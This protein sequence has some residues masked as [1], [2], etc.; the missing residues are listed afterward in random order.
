M[1]TSKPTRRILPTTDKPLT[2]MDDPLIKAA[3]NRLDSVHHEYEVGR[4]VVA[5]LRKYFPQDKGWTIVPEFLVP[6]RKKP[7]YCVE[8]FTGGTSPTFTP[9]VFI[10]IKSRQGD[11]TE[12]ALDQVTSSMV[13]T[14]DRL[15]GDFACF[16]ILVKGKQIGFFEYHNDRSNLAEDGVM[17]HY[18]AISF[19][20][21]QQPI[22]TKRPF[23]RGAG[24]VT[25]QD[26]YSYGYL[27]PQ[28]EVFLDLATEDVTVQKI[29]DWMREQEPLS[30]PSGT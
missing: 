12:K 26:E 15:G 18:G 28:D 22:P 24:Y 9:K 1:S 16:I 6:E 19:N 14:V 3:V 25:H 11:T 20:N 2:Y 27:P 5:I 29:M 23:Y 13:Q 30:S 7:D 21:P 8:K 10:E 17:H 4:A